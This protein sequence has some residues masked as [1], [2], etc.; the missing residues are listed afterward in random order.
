[1]NTIFN[2]TRLMG[3]LTSKV[4]VNEY[5]GT[6][7]ANFTL[8]TNRPG[9]KDKDQISDFHDCTLW[10]SVVTSIKDKLEGSPL[11][12]IEG[13]IRY[14]PRKEAGDDRITNKQPYIQVN[15][16]YIVPNTAKTSTEEE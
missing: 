8:V 12:S 2:S 13:E 11:V 15:S 1:M 4:R 9:K 6:P 5:D 10:G 14:K 7:V 16:I 3:R